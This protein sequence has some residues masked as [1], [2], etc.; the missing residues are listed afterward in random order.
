MNKPERPGLLWGGGALSIAGVLTT[1][2]APL[3]VDSLG[4]AGLATATIGG[5]LT[6]LH[7]TQVIVIFG[8]GATGLV[9]RF[10]RRFS[11][12]AGCLL[13]A[14]ALIVAGVSTSPSVLFLLM[15]L[16]GFGAGLAYAAGGS[17]LSYAHD[18]ERAYSIVTIASILIGALVLTGT[19]LIPTGH[20]QLG[21]LWGIALVLV[22]LGIVGLR[23]PRMQP[24][25]NPSD[26]GPA[27]T[28]ASE[29]KPGAGD[30]GWLGPP[31]LALIGGYFLLNVGILAVWTYSG[32]VAQAA[33][34]TSSASWWFLGLSQALSV[35]GC[36]IAWRM[37]SRPGKAWVLVGSLVALMAGKF[38]IGTADLWPYV[39]GILI[40]NLTFYTVIPFVF[41]AGADLN[42]RS[43]RLVVVVGA[44]AMAAGAVAPA[45]GGFLAG[46]D[47]QWLR[48]G[49]GASLAILASIPLLL[50]AVRAAVAAKAQAAEI[51]A[52]VAPLL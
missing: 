47:G 13:G 31:G 15:I 28:P 9:A 36:L 52:T 12:L 29:S 48:L 46:D 19:A 7:L 32:S 50:F 3:L 11:G 16:V 20:N 2:I 41:A 6:A 5:Y 21:I 8:L 34:M 23:I 35:A 26:P 10:D 27:A 38:L 25:R 49:V 17:A 51:E 33:G 40:T 44:S 18:T 4:A 22:S 39:V 42:P 24:T 30:R 43:G 1:I 37:G 14:G 45:L